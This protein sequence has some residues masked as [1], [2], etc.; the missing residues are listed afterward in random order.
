MITIVI[1]TF[2][3]A[4]L[5]VFT[6]MMQRMQYEFGTSIR[7]SNEARAAME[8]IVWGTRAAGGAPDR[9]GIW[10][11]QAYN[12]VSPT[13]F[14]Y[15][16]MLGA[17]HG[18]RLNGLK[19]ETRA[20]PLAA[21]VPVLDLQGDPTKDSLALDFTETRPNVVQIR[22]VLGERVVGR[23]QYASLSTQVDVRNV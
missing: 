8:K 20:N 2:M 10:E 6:T 15:T 7:L 17:V 12:V 3:T 14:S 16:D 11:A 23:W 9:H 19:V 5:L 1:I 13:E 18:I 4:G 21:W 22:L